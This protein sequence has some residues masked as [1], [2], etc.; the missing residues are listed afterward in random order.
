MELEPLSLFYITQGVKK[1]FIKVYS[2][3]TEFEIEGKKDFAIHTALEGP[4]LLCFSSKHV[5]LAGFQH[6]IILKCA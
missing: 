3:Q 5:T 2:H 4:R 6:F 1:L